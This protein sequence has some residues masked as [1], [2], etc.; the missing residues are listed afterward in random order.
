MDKNKFKLPALI[1][2][3]LIFAVS[4][5]ACGKG[6][7]HGK[8]G[9]WSNGQDDTYSTLGSEYDELHNGQNPYAD[10]L[11]SGNGS[12]GK[13]GSASRDTTALKNFSY[14]WTDSRDIPPVIIVVDDFGAADGSL[15]QGFADLPPEVVFAILP[16]LPNTKK[17]AQIASQ[18]GHEVLIHAPMEAISSTTKPGDR[19]IKTNQD[20]ATIT[21]MLDSFHE[22]IPNAIGLNNHM[23]SAA[24]SDKNVM[25]VVLKHLNSKGLF[26]M[27][28]MTSGSSVG[29]KLAYSLG[30]KSIR[31]DIFLDVP[32]N[33]DATIASKISELGKYKGRTQPIVIITHCHNQAKLNA[34]RTFISQ[35][36]AMGVNITSFSRGYAAGAMPSY[37]MS[38]D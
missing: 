22:Q 37:V 8:D 24:T 9:K 5:T 38:L 29:Y 2:L 11:N 36:K 15:L 19:Y 3:I 32:D 27:D 1:A 4:I 14:T 31:R 33:T 13:Y 35:I 17:T 20:D 34:L 28:S 23:G 10:S 18:H 12:G 25:A 6:G 30:Y 16:D 21:A 26:F 7:K